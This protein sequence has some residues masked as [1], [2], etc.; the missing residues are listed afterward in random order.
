[1]GMSKEMLGNQGDDLRSQLSYEPKELKFGTSGRR[2]QVVDLTQLEI[3]INVLAELEY[4]QTLTHADGGIVSGEEFYFARDLRPSSIAYVAEQL[5]RGEIAQ[6]VVHAIR[7]AGMKPVNL[8]CIPTPA[9]SG[10]ALA[11]RKGSIMVTGSHIPFDHNGYK[12]NTCQG[13]LLKQHEDPIHEAVQQVRARIYQAPFAASLFDRS[14]RFKTGHTELPPEDQSAKAAYVERFLTFFDGE[15]LSGMRLLVYQHSAVGRD[16]IVDILKA[17][18]AEVILMGRSDSFVPIDTENIDAAQLAT[19][20]ALT[21]AATAQ[22]GMVHAVV[23]MDGD[24]DRPLLLGVDFATSEVQFFSGDLVGI[25]VA[26][27]LDADAVVVPISC[28]DAIDGSVLADVVETKTRIGSPYVIAG[29]ES[30]LRKG[31]HKVCGWEAN[32]GFLTGSE[33]V[34]QGKTLLALPTRDAVLPILCTLFSA[35]KK[36]LSL[37]ELFAKLPRRYSRAA[38]LKHFQRERALRIVQRFSPSDIRVKEALFEDDSVILRD[39]RN[40]PIAGTVAGVRNLKDIREQIAAFFSSS[41]GFGSITRLNYVDGIRITF[42]NGD[43]A[44]LRPSGNADE[45]RIYSVANTQRRAEAIAALG[46]AEPS[47]ILRAMERAVS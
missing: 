12:T 6:G 19:I 41:N 3:Y 39:E 18:G 38:L 1:M 45:L 24:S 4:L 11:R 28:N 46:V 2:G 40:A 44:H 25:V 22:C 7:D 13:E 15:S 29:M 34:R 36:R 23:S 9:L 20:Q 14:G 17:L 42:S 31:R 16:L 47:G 10:Y 33:I 27:F 43:V 8:G 21:R 30:A 5:G 26:E 32:G 37:A 35:H